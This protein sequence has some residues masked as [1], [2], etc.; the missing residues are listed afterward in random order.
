MALLGERIDAYEI[1]HFKFRAEGSERCYHGRARV[2]VRF[3]RDVHRGT[4]DHI[5]VQK[6][7]LWQPDTTKGPS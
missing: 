1:I 3:P 5:V 7:T 4:V 6:R 2:A